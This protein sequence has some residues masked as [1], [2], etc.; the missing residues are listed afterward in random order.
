VT[1]SEDTQRKN[2]DLIVAKTRDA[3]AKFLTKE[4]VEE[5]IAAMTEK[6]EKPVDDALATITR[7]AKRHLFTDT[8]AASILDC[9][10]KGGDLTA[11]GVMQA[12]TAAAQ[13]IT[14]P[15]RAAE[16]EDLASAVLDTAAAL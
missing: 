7:V 5:A 1:W 10:I 8:E 11:G 6:A 16:F 3:V 9:F 15:D 4:F 2:L 14:D 12:V 13:D